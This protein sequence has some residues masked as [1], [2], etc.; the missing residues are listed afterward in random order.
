MDANRNV[1]NVLKPA[2]PWPQPVAKRF[3]ASSG[4]V[5]RKI[6]DS[7][8]RG[9]FDYNPRPAKK[10]N[11]TAYDL[12]QTRELDD[13]LELIQKFVD[14]AAARVTERKGVSRGGPGRPPTNAA[15]VAKVLLAQTY[16]GVPNR[17]AEGFLYLFAAKL[18][19]RDDF[20]YKTIERGYDR[21]AVQEILDE[22]VV[23]TNL[24]VR[25][26]EKV[27]AVDGTGETRTGKT[28]RA[29]CG[30]RG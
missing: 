17:V 18:D 25:G 4:Q 6:I 27:F 12:A 23:L 26:L 2:C 16:L 5:V 3:L 20:S 15:D 19:I 24:P 13:T 8:R 29:A 11:W 10:V 9:E 30:G 14:R 21:E 22:V 28:G 7:A 1:R